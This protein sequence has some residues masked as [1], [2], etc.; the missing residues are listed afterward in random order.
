[1]IAVAGRG[2]LGF[3]TTIGGELGTRGPRIASAAAAADDPVGL[4]ADNAFES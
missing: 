1:M 4:H 3:S 2:A